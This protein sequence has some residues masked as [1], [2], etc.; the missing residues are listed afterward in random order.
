MRRW[1]FYLQSSVTGD[2]LLTSFVKAWKAGF[3]SA[4][5]FGFPLR[6]LENSGQ[7]RANQKRGGS[8]YSVRDREEIESSPRAVLPLVSRRRIAERPAQSLARDGVWSRWP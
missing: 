4:G 3:L 5:G 6:M 1:H 2:A 7:S 8:K